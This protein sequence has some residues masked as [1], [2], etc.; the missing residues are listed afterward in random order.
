[1]GI[2][3]EQFLETDYVKDIIAK[4]QRSATVLHPQTSNVPLSIAV[5][6]F[7]GIPNL[8]GF[9][10]YPHCDCCNT[11][12]NFVLQLYKDEFQELYFPEGKS[13]FQLF[14]CPNGDC[15]DAYPEK[16]Y[17]D[18]KMFV[19]YHSIDKIVDNLIKMPVGNQEGMEFPVPDCVLKPVKLD[20]FPID[21]DYG[22]EINN[23][24]VLYG[25]EM[26]DYFFDQ[27]YAEQRTKVGGYPNFAQSPYYPKCS[28][29]KQKEFFF[30]L[31]SD[32][33]EEGVLDPVPDKWS[34]H[35][36]MI[37]DLGNI[38]FYVCKCCGENSI[39]SYWDCH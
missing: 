26:S 10:T 17:Y 6:K 18:L 28:C 36:I 22:I 23:M 20:D 25:A 33:Q 2:T 13:L 4:Y 19:Y 3:E 12:L 35:R 31:S 1:M 29:G 14:R 38:Y 21:E 39:E 37:G 5:S 16:D 8:S 32:D 15:Q 7:G 27:F 30:Q 9:N 34:P 11:P 24:Q